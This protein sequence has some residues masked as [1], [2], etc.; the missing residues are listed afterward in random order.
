MEHCVCCRAYLSDTTVSY[1]EYTGMNNGARAPLEHNVF[2]CITVGDSRLAIQ[3]PMGADR[4][5]KRLV[6]GDAGTSQF[7]S[8][9]VRLC[10]AF[11]RYTM[12][13]RGCRYASYQRV[14]R[15][16]GASGG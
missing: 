12:I 5:R 2:D 14:D 15:Q 6:A 11:A 8:R 1:A 10:T 4:M 3:Q 16:I 13:K 7:I 9:L